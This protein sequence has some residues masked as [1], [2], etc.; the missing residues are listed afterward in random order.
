MGRL[1][2]RAAMT[3]AKAAAMSSVYLFGSRPMT[4]AARMPARPAS[5][6]ETTQTPA[7]M[8]D[9]L[10]PDSDVIASESTIAR[11][12][13]PASVKRRISAPNT[14]MPMHA[15]VGDHLVEGDRG[16]EPLVDRDRLRREAGR[17]EDLVVAEDDLG[18][19]R[20]DH[21]QADGDHDLDQLRRQPQEAEDR[22]VEEDPHERR[23]DQQADR[24]AGEDAPLLLDVQEVVEAR[25]EEGECAEGEVEHA[26]RHVRDDEAGRGERVDAPEHESDDDELQHR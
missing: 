15:G 6:V 25:D 1:R 19:H 21:G 23:E 12:L 5:M 3:A 10:L 22:H 14:T 4:G 18:E 8:R 17:L 11:T 26:G 24:N 13:R 9:G 20:D 7:A 16:V 2:S